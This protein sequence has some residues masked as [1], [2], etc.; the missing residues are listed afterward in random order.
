MIATLLLLLSILQGGTADARPHV[1][2]RASTP[3]QAVTLAPELL[4]AGPAQQAIAPSGTVTYYVFLPLTARPEP[5][6][7]EQIPGVQYASLSVTPQTLDAAEHPDLNLAL[8]GYELTAAYCGLVDYGGTG[9]AR[10]PQLYT[11]FADGRVPVFPAVY[12]VYDWDWGRDCRGV[13]LTNPPVTLAGM[14]VPPGEVLRLPDSGYD[15]GSD[16]EALVLYA[17]EGRITLSYTREDS[18]VKGYTVHVENVCVEPSLLALYE[19][20]DDAGRVQL[21]ALRG[22]QPFGRALGTE[23]R[24]AIRD[25]GTFMD[26]RSRKDWWQ[27]K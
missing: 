4:A 16:Y 17:T 21:P 3:L 12:Q 8:R 18:V 10:A 22:G 25:A 9:D 20:L 27:G 24:V 11:L 1:V 2:V 15:I 5:S 26:P 14:G 19:T 6:G 23:I 13:L 7:C